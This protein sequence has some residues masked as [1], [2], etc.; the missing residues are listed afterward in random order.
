MVTKRLEFSSA[1]KIRNTSLMQTRNVTVQS[2][3]STITP[4]MPLYF[5]QQRNKLFISSQTPLTLRASIQ[6]AQVEYQIRR[7]G[8]GIGP[9]QQWVLVN[10]NYTFHIPLTL[11]DGDYVI[12]HRA[13]LG[14]L[15]GIISEFTFTLDNTPPN[16]RIYDEQGNEIQGSEITIIEGQKIILQATDSGS[17]VAKIV[18]RIDNG[19]LIEV[20]GD[21][22]EIQF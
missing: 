1:D 20:Q 17:G 16:V 10:N 4:G 12:Y 8:A 2:L 7:A 14:N 15:R 9:D 22:A 21:R 5:D 13:V 3:A 18:Y 6:N 11:Q 19:E